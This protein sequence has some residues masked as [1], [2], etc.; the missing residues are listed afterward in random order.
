[1]HCVHHARKFR[2][3][4]D[5]S[6]DTRCSRA[7]NTQL[8]RVIAERAIHLGPLMGGVFGRTNEISCQHAKPRP[9][10]KNTNSCV[11]LI[12]CKLLICDFIH[13]FHTPFVRHP[14]QMNGENMLWEKRCKIY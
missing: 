11:L 6:H 5:A 4:I 10:T 2:L 7:L 9:P 12:I 13:S 1:M 14:V 3:R 8:P